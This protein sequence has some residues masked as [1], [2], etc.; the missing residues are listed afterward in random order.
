MFRQEIS[1]AGHQGNIIESQPLVRV[2]PDEFID[3]LI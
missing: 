1:V 3:M 2:G